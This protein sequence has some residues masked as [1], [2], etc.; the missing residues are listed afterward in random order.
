MRFQLLFLV[1]NC[2]GIAALFHSKCAI[3]KPRKPEACLPLVM[4]S[5]NIPHFQFLFQCLP[6]TAVSCGQK[7]MVIS[8]LNIEEITLY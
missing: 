7:F 4:T 2:D 3:F 5:S 6:E 1:N 8:L